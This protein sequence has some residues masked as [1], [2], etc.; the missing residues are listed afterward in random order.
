MK[1]ELNKGFI[2]RM[3]ARFEQYE[4]EVGVLEDKDHREPIIAGL[5]EEAKLASYAGGPV[6]KASRKSSG[7]S[8]GDVLVDN[9]ERLNI[10]LLLEPFLKTNSEIMKFTRYFMGLAAGRKNISMKRIENLLQAIVR[11]PILNQE[12]GENTAAAA[13]AKGFDR[14]LIDTG[15]MFKAIKARVTRVRKKA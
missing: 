14:L 3:N 11:N 5:F 12:Y 9:M 7:L 8:V 1:V 10:N 15:Q 4:C 6:R 2:K 13:D